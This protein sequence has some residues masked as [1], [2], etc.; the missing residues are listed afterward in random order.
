MR[1][2][3]PAFRGAGDGPTVVEG[4]FVCALG[5]A[6]ALVELAFGEWRMTTSWRY[7]GRGWIGAGPT[8]RRLLRRAYVS[9][10]A[11]VPQQRDEMP[12]LTHLRGG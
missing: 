5:E 7:G 11:V 9:R 8:T 10:Q 12:F 2:R 6:Q 4:K 3:A 1:G